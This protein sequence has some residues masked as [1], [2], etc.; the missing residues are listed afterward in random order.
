MPS[1]IIKM[2]GNHVPSTIGGTAASI[3]QRPLNAAKLSLQ[4]LHVVGLP[5]SS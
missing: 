4:L 5:E 3:L 2:N 1:S